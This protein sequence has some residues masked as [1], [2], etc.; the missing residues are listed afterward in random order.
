M[1]GCASTKPTKPTVID[2]GP[3]PVLTGTVQRAS[4]NI[5]VL[6][7]RKAYNGRS[8][9]CPGADFDINYEQEWL[10]DF[11]ITNRT[12][13]LSFEATRDG[14]Q[15]AIKTATTGFGHEDWLWIGLSSHGA[16]VPDYNGDEKSGYDTAWCLADGPWVDDGVGAFI[17][18]EIPPCQIVFFADTCFSEGSFRRFIPGMSRKQPVIIQM[19]MGKWKGS[20]V[21]LAAC[22]DT[23]S[24]L[25]GTTGGQ[26]HLAWDEVYEKSNTLREMFTAASELV[27]GHTPVLVL[28][29]PLA[30][31]MLDQPLR[32]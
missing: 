5:G 4:V 10:S 20:I 26:W 12:S 28:Y 13:L 14:V 3:A 23:E 21:Q 19:P 25:G 17:E 27:D 9:L 29:G 15:N 11:G 18:A 2:Y 32:K 30:E 7:T 24:A 6:S 8:L 1:T 22:R 16:Q 31:W